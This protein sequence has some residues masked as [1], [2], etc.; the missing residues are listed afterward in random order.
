MGFSNNSFFRFRERAFLRLCKRLLGACLIAFVSLV[1]LERESVSVEDAFWAYDD[2][3][4]GYEE[5]EDLLRA[6][7]EGAAE[8]CRL[9]ESYG[10]EPCRK[11]LG[12]RLKKLNFR[13]MSGYSVSLDSVGNVRRER[14]RLALGARRFDGEARIASENRGKPL[15]ERFRIAY[16][17]GKSFAV[18]GDVVA[19][20]IGSALSLEKTEGTVVV[21]GGKSFSLGASLLPDTAFGGSLS[22]GRGMFRFDGF[23]MVSRNGF[24]DA[25]LRIRSVDSDVQ[26]AYSR[27]W[28]TPL[29]YVSARS[30]KSRRW[31]VRFLSYFHGNHLFSGIFHVP[32][33]VEKNRA[34]GNALIKYRVSDWMLG[35]S[36]NF[37]IPLESSVAKSELE[38]SIG[39]DGSR[40]KIAVGSRLKF[41]G[42]SLDMA[43]FLHSG[44]C[45]FEAESLFG[46]WKWM[47][48]YPAETGRYEIRSGV[49]ILVDFPV[50]VS[51]VL[52]L[53]GPE[54]KPLAFRGVTQMD[55]SKFLSGKS[56]IELRGNRFREFAL[57]RFGM[58]VSG[59]W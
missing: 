45:L 39:K 58:E 5:L 21:L 16:R 3:V 2:G 13:G 49:R 37:L 14:F 29:L 53:R 26:V 7:D 51:A 9:W 19:S 52:I 46:E 59:K 23:A 6:I 22:F 1:A 55:F 43:Y 40:A 15:V 12:E 42:D 4:I 10:G 33:I 20:D 31:L 28:E 25:F 24:R 32:K 27:G 30:G 44:I 41:F 48:R 11:S 36:G 56:S 38:A 57:W 34:V 18:W 17:D 54:K 47:Q 8:A 50:S 35:L